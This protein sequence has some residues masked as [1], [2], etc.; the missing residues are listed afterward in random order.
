VPI[1]TW[2]QRYYLDVI[3]YSDAAN[4]TLRKPVNIPGSLKGL[5][6]DGELLYTVGYHWDAITF[7]TDWTE[8]LDASAYDGVSASLV[9]SLSLSQSWPHPILVDGKAIFVGHPAEN[10]KSKSLLEVWTLADSGKFAPLANPPVALTSAAQ[11]FAAFGDLLAVQ[12]SD[13]IELFNKAIPATLSL[14]GQNPSQSCIGYDVGNA[15]GAVDR[16]LW[17]PLGDY[18]VLKISVPGPQASPSG[19]TASGP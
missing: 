10:D 6:L 3:D 14:L 8:H 16:G 12:T 17:L 19:T 11:N 1:G 2:V 9:D 7:T 18:G 4:P 5:S 13:T 15:D